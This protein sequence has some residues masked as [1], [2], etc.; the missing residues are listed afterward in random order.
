MDA[1][2][3][4][5]CRRGSLATQFFRRTGAVMPE[6]LG[7]CEGMPEQFFFPEGEQ[8]DLLLAWLAY[9]GYSDDEL[10]DRSVRS[11]R[12]LCT[13]DM[14]KN[15]N[16]PS[17]ARFTFRPEL[18]SRQFM[19]L[20]LSWYGVYPR[21]EPSV[22]RDTL[23]DQV[24]ALQKAAAVTKG[25]GEDEE[26][27]TAATRFARRLCGL[28]A[29]RRFLTKAAGQVD[30]L[31]RARWRG[32]QTSSGTGDTARPEK[33]SRLQTAKRFLAGTLDSDYIA[34]PLIVIGREVALRYDRKDLASAVEDNERFVRSGMQALVHKAPA[35][36]HKELFRKM[37]QIVVPAL[38]GG[39]TR[40]RE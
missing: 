39:S 4:P 6:D 2:V 38:I 15:G 28:R 29:L 18:A 9:R 16:V 10:R 21:Q 20:W 14:L 7:V 12:E 36:F 35:G 40:R 11:L 3:R 33:E 22:S 34:E 8:Q 25:G 17:F 31:D 19:T 23:E 30:V 5:M 24:L 26:E 13:D 32:V 37:V 27:S 1:Y